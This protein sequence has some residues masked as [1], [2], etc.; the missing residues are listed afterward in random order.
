M[1]NYK[2]KRENFCFVIQ[3]VFIGKTLKETILEILVF[4]NNNPVCAIIQK[5]FVSFA[6]Y[7]LVQNNCHM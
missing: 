3:T 6:D 7:K 1:V 2:N 4:V 5:C